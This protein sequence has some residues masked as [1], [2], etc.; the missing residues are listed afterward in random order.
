[1]T[2]W[3]A[4]SCMKPQQIL[5]DFDAFTVDDIQ[6]CLVCAADR[7]KHQLIVNA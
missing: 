2:F 3:I 5:E 4:V 1:M 6:A 7:E